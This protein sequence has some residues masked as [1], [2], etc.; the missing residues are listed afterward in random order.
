[1]DAFAGTGHR[2]SIGS[3]EPVGGLF[4]DDIEED[5]EV[6]QFLRGSAVIA[7]ENQPPFSEYLFLEKKPKYAKELN[8][9][10][11]QYVHLGSP[12]QIHNKEANQFLQNWCQQTDWRTTRAVV[13]LDPYG[14]Q[15]KW[16]TLEMIAKTQGID[17]W[18]LFP[19]GQAVNRL[20]TRKGLPDESQSKRL[21][22]LFGTTDWQNAFY[23]TE[24]VKDLFDIRE[25]TSK[26]ANL[27]AIGKFFVER[28]SA[29]F[30]GVA[31]NPRP[32]K[33]S[34]GVPIYLLCFA[35]ANPK[36]ASTAIR[37]ASHILGH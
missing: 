3:N 2:D 12:I 31:K 26:I 20:L 7:L 23:R 1:M 36:G 29:I 17:L 18:I 16:Q 34:R 5:I 4:D 9:L 33:N 35:A 14:M 15:V 24:I 37:I 21:T 19:L 6:Q 32:L 25:Q 10:R 27:E 8:L 28:L 22:E 13:F 30:K 11:D